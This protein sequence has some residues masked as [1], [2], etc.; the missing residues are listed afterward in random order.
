ML[1]LF[2][3]EPQLPCVQATYKKALTMSL[4]LSYFRTA[5]SLVAA[6]TL[7]FVSANIATAQVGGPEI[8]PFAE[9]L[10]GPAPGTAAPGAGAS[11]APGAPTGPPQQEGKTAEEVLADAQELFENGDFG[12][13][14]RIYNMMLTRIPSN[15]PL[16]VLKGRCLAELGEK[17]LALSSFT[18][19][20]NY[21]PSSPVPP[22]EKGKIYYEMRDYKN[23]ASEFTKAVAADPLNTESLLERGKSQLKLAQLS[24]NAPS[25]LGPPNTGALVEQAISS[26]ERVT[27]I[28]P[29]NAEAYS[30]LARAK[31]LMQQ[32]DEAVEDA[33]RARQLAADD[34]QQTARLGIAYQSRGDSEKAKRFQ[35]D[36]NKAV[37]DYRYAIDQFTEF[38][39]VNGDP[40][41]DQTQYEEDPDLI[42]PKAIYQYR[43][44]TYNSLANITSNGSMYY[45][46]SIADCNKLLEYKEST[47]QVKAAALL[48]RGM[49]QRMLGDNQAAIESYN[50]TINVAGPIPDALIRRGIIYYHM[51][52]LDSAMA[53]FNE[54]I[55]QPGDPRDVRAKFWTGV[56]HARRG[57]Y[58]DAI[59][60]Y[61][62]ALRRAPGYKP[63]RNNRGLA[64][65]R[66]GR[67][68][69]AAED[70]A[71]LVRLDAKDTVSRSR[72]DQAYQLLRAEMASNRR[73]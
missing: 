18:A 56:V 35:K 71:E 5:F 57:E 39:N 34:L 44:A 32:A 16:N 54:A 9:D 51:N 33:N 70:F 17:E 36:L 28:D 2:A 59:R 13:A 45:Q 66:I 69:Q 60:L 30:Q 61:S 14:L 64:L 3:S 48:Q 21:L 58:Y 29:K 50:E 55:V 27:E 52:D 22:M 43:I 46:N 42:S 20:E 1:R 6:S 10:G 38:L 41:L 73:Y 8:D 68:R 24:L 7:L 19:A 72:R 31:S 23:A 15:G 25:L 4:R 65:M 49:A 40:G 11:G 53:D 63:A 26:L 12:G 47:G 62:S 67:Y 37:S